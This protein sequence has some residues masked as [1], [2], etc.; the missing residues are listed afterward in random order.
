[1][2]CL[3]TRGCRKIYNCGPKPTGIGAFLYVQLKNNSI[4]NK[5]LWNNEKES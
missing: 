1:M 5:L 4:L 3:M 2:L